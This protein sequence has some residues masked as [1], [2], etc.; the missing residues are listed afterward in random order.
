VTGKR[1]LAFAALAGLLASAAGAKELSLAEL[2]RRTAMEDTEM[3]RR[4][5]EIEAM[6]SD[7][8][9]TAIVDAVK[10]QTIIFYQ[11]GHGVYVEYVDAKD[12]VYM[13]YRGN[14]QVVYGTWGVRFFDG[15]PKVCY[16]YL[17]SV[18]G[19]TGEYE[20]TEC[21][22]PR[23]TL[24]AKERLDSRP[25]DPFGLASGKLPYRKS[26]RDVP[27]WPEGEEPAE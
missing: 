22:H 7:E 20:P 12:R 8:I 3:E 15:V 18:N 11:P 17:D 9:A 26:D 6:S 25:G 4:L 21:I 1:A 5:A 10:D 23:Q 14:R 13:W 19:V 27:E 2:E 24:L 16:H